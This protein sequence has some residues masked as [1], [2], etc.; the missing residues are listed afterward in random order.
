M[1]Q[2]SRVDSFDKQ[3]PPRRSGPRTYAFFFGQIQNHPNF[4]F[5]S[6]SFLFGEFA[7]NYG[8]CLFHQSNGIRKPSR[9]LIS[10]F[11][12]YPL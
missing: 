1:L 5:H 3:Y 11:L 12:P 10:R 8:V 7:A 2:I 9:F 4:N 6:P